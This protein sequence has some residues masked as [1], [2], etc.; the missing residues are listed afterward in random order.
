MKSPSTIPK[1]DMKRFGSR[2]IP[3]S[4]DRSKLKLKLQEWM[5]EVVR[6][7]KH[8]NKIRG[9][10][11]AKF[12]VEF[13]SGLD[14]LQST[15]SMH[16]GKGDPERTVYAKYDFASM[17]NGYWYVTHVTF[18]LLTGE[19]AKKFQE[20][21]SAEE[22]AELK[23]RL[24]ARVEESNRL[25]PKASA[26]QAALHVD[27]WTNDIKAGAKLLQKDMDALY[28][29]AAKAASIPENPISV[30]DAAMGGVGKGVGALGTASDRAAM[31]ADTYDKVDK[32]IGYGEK[33]VKYGA[34]LKGS[35]PEDLLK[36]SQSKIY[37]TGAGDIVADELIDLAAN[38]PGAGPFV[39]GFAGMFFHFASMNYAGA[40][41]KVRGRLYSW[42][43]AGYVQGLTNVALESPPN[44]ALDKHFFNLGLAT[45]L[46]DSE[47]DKFNVQ[48]FLLWYSSEHYIIGSNS[49]GVRMSKPLDW[50]FPDGYLAFWS[51]ERLGHSLATLLKTKRY[52]VD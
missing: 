42:Y 31:L 23:A 27:T 10:E 28:E 32:A 9:M 15:P 16:I 17:P 14:E 19:A 37:K 7:T 43:I 41:A 45:T 49:P 4:Q 30:K 20:Q 40:V 52:L 47:S 18:S 12:L 46:R 24:L 2:V 51:P 1:P 35:A 36:Q 48:I 44:D 13:A 3:V 33:A 26:F 11:P 39:K 34:K 6:H 5:G 21:R 8:P 50:T 22:K 25:H 38:L 29:V